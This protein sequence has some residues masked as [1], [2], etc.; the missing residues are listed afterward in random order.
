MKIEVKLPLIE[1]HWTHF[2]RLGAL[3]CRVTLYSGSMITVNLLSLRW[4]LLSN[5]GVWFGSL[6]VR[7][8]LTFGFL[9]D[10]RNVMLLELLFFMYIV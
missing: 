7:I 3:I 5:L 6:L 2:S 1:C 10:L 4:S 9:H 8:Q